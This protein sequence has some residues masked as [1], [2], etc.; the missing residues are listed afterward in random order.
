[1]TKVF[2]ATMTDD[3]GTRT[4]MVQAPTK[5]EAAAKAEEW[6]WEPSA[7]SIRETD[8]KPPVQIL[9]FKFADLK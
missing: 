4:I 5:Q 1:M 6:G 9:G 7:C 8:E 2:H 3:V